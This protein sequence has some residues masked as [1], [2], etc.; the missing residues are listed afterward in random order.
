[1]Y[2]LWGAPSARMDTSPYQQAMENWKRNLS[3]LF[4]TAMKQQSSE[5]PTIQ[6]VSEGPTIQPIST[7]PTIQPVPQNPQATPVPTNGAPIKMSD[8]IEDGTLPENQ[9][10][11]AYSPFDTDVQKGQLSIQF[12]DTDAY[13]NK[14][15]NVFHPEDNTI[16]TGGNYQ[17][18]Y[19]GNN[20]GDLA[21]YKVQ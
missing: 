1:M 6:P 15:Y 7:G 21:P 14:G 19:E 3:Q 18:Y 10:K 20:Y 11:V 2:G 12:G 9:F 13:G 16:T 5:G 17:E 4:G 8:M